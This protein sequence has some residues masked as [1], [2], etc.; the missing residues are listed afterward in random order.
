MI[1]RLLGTIIVFFILITSSCSN[2]LDV[3][4]PYK[5]TTIIYGLI[6]PNDSIQYIKIYKAFLGDGNAFTFAQVADSFYFKDVL[7]ANLIQIRSGYPNDTILLQRDTIAPQQD[8]IFASTP[9]I[10]YTTS[11]QIDVISTYKLLIKNSL[12][13]SLVSAQTGIPQNALL[14]RPN[15]NNTVV[16]L[17]GD[18]LFKISWRSGLHGKVYNLVIR[19]HYTLITD[20]TQKS[21]YIDWL[22]G[23]K[24]SP[25]AA[26]NVDMQVE[27][28]S[29]AFY[30]Y[31]GAKLNPPDSGSYRKVGKLEFI[32]IGG[33]E[34]FYYYNLINNVSVGVNQTL[35]DYTNITNGLG[36]F[37]SKNTNSWFFELSNNSY[38]YLR[39]S[40]YTSDLK[41]Y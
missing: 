10:V 6:S 14:Y 22:A 16:N 35:P 17:L 30:K 1:F 15:T 8:G 39:N 3:T 37:S 7:T 34:A 12:N 28:A 18:S 19:F 2:E 25:N 41:F 4:A 26:P 29:D 23:K 40:A 31:L 24:I 9:N 13:G 27:K 5:D 36:L 11:E 33:D 20:S 32:V 21:M 38:D